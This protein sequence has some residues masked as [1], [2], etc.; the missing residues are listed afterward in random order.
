M[1]T[2]EYE[3]DACGHEFERLQRMTDPAVK[4]C[5]KCAKL[6]V[7]RLISG[8][9]GVI[10]KG[11]GFYETDYKRARSPGGRKDGDGA[12]SDTK[13]S[14]SK[15]SDTKGSDS[16]SS[17]SKSSDSKSTDSKPSDSKSSEPARG[18]TKSSDAKSADPKPS[19]KT[20]G[21]SK[22]DGGGR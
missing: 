13:S 6:K 4:K 16:K 2:Y 8:G 7:R 11:S 17:E 5:P 22:Q 1:P 12:S 19:P 21:R 3:C 15:P 14:D 9:A 18:A 10:F 20:P